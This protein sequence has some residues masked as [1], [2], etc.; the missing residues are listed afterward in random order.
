MK[1][2]KSFIT[3]RGNY[4]AHMAKI[5][6]GNIKP[7]D[8]ILT[9]FNSVIRSILSKSKT[10]CVVI[11]SSGSTNDSKIK[12]LLQDF[13]DI[14]NKNK[15]DI[16]NA[17]APEIFKQIQSVE[18]L[19]CRGPHIGLDMVFDLFD[20]NTDDKEYNYCLL[21]YDGQNDGIIPNDYIDGVIAFSILEE[22][23]KTVNILDS[24]SV[25]IKCKNEVIS[26]YFPK[27]DIFR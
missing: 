3:E 8:D 18:E 7:V 15:L 23:Y 22:G 20:T 14:A 9:S 6:H 16:Y 19:T 25:N 21:V 1:N 13:I 10:P 24:D 12:S 2:I 17:A 26:Y 27:K 4:Y 5:N 11:L